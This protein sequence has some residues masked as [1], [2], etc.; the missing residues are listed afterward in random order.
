MRKLLPLLLTTSLA[1][2]LSGCTSPELKMV[3]EQ[4]SPVFVYTDETKELIS[5][6]DSYCNVRMYEMS[7]HK[8]G[9][10]SGSTRKAPISYCDRCVGFKKYSEWAT[11]WEVVRRSVAD[12]MGF[13]T[14][15]E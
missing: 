15:N 6:K 9:A 4:C 3:D 11:F 2:F 7:I 8:V 14:E 1:S 12:E 10:Q 13:V 5:A